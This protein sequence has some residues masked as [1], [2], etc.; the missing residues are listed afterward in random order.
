MLW[1]EIDAHYG[2]TDEFTD[3][4]IFDAFRFIDLDKNMF[5]GSA[6]IRHILICMGELVTDEEIDVMIKMC[7]TDGDGQVS[8]EEFY[9]LAK[10]PDPSR[11][12]FNSSM[13]VPLID[14]FSNIYW[15][16]SQYF[17][18]LVH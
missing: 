12:D 8:Y 2:V 16:V 5:I 14:V 1:Q 6:E 10:H 7:D 3:K 9:R 4:E 18:A 17:V 15:R 13:F 11:P